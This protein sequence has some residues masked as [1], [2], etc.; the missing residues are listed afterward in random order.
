MAVLQV[1][2]YAK[3]L[4]S[5]FHF[6]KIFRTSKGLIESEVSQRATLQSDDSSG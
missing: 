6:T 5:D 3:K 4:H 1:A 2:F